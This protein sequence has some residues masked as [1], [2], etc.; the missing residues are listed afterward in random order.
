[1]SFS[2]ATAAIWVI[3]WPG[4]TSWLPNHL[5]QNGSRL[6]GEAY[7]GTAIPSWK[8][9][10]P[11]CGRFLKIGDAIVAR[12]TLYELCHPVFGGNAKEDFGR[13]LDKWIRRTKR[14]Y[15]RGAAQLF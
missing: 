1:M 14:L 2:A 3:S 6:V 5:R 13:W 4:T 10:F 15:F 8:N 11:L 9:L 12:R 7:R